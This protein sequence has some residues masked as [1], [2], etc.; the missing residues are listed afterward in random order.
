MIKGSGIIEMHGFLQLSLQYPCVRACVCAFLNMCAWFP[1]ISSSEHPHGFTNVW[2]SYLRLS[3]CRLPIRKITL[4]EFI[5]TTIIPACVLVCMCALV[6]SET[7]GFLARAYVGVHVCASCVFLSLLRGDPTHRLSLTDS[8][9]IAT[10]R[11]QRNKVRGRGEDEGEQEEGRK[12]GRE[13][14][15]E[16]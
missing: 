16:M 2:R 1:L 6:R 5:S 3:D 11:R 12:E 9:F 10:E 15:D 13:R 14:N 7:E 4:S 8:V